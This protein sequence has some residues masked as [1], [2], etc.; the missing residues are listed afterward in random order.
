[1]A[2]L[3]SAQN[4]LQYLRDRH[5]SVPDTLNS[6]QIELLENTKNFNLLLKLTDDRHL[7]VKQ[8]RYISEGKSAGEFQAEWQV[9]QLVHR[10]PDLQSHQDYL[11]EV[12]GFDADRSILICNYLQ[13]YR[14]LFDFYLKEKQYPTEIAA[15]V[16]KTIATIHRSTFDQTEYREFLQP[17][18]AHLPVAQLNRLTPELFGAVP[19]DGIKFFVLYQRYDSLGQA[20][21]ALEANAS[22][23]CLTHNDF[24]LNNILLHLNWEES[25]C[26]IRLIDWERARWGDPASDLGSLFCGYLQ[27]WLSSL[28]VSHDMA[29]EE[30][31]RL[32]MTPLELLQPSM[33][34][35]MTAYLG[36][37]PE[38]LTHQPN[39][40]NRVMQFTGLALIQQIQAGIQYEKTFGNTGICM[41]QVAKSLLCR[42][43]QALLTVFGSAF[44]SRSDAAISSATSA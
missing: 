16:G 7:L 6:D 29:I 38:I 23:R 34:A 41:L 28:V 22:A 19:A 24:K 4:V 8:E 9:Q 36:A 14:D 26:P 44:S 25:D 3:L 43:E 35:C 31:L 27:L 39:F 11:P 30:S 21:A 13:N 10:F 15:L 5:L 2:F 33:A 42:P 40:L 17:A 32:A 1:M 20:I 18:E 37:F 12:L